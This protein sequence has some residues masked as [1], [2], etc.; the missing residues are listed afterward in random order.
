MTS[1]D[2]TAIVGSA[3]HN[4]HQGSDLINNAQRTRGTKAWLI[5]ELP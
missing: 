5:L 2:C 1:H 3:K 4:V